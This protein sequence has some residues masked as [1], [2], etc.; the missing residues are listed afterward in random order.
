[1]IARVKY[2]VRIL[3]LVFLGVAIGISYYIAYETYTEMS[4]GGGE[5]GE[6]I[7]LLGEKAP[8]TELHLG[9]V[10]EAKEVSGE[11]SV[12]SSGGS[13]SPSSIEEKIRATF[14]EEPTTAVAVAMC[15]SR[16]D[17]S[18]IGDTHIQEPSYGLFQINRFYNPQYSVD[19]LSTVDGN[20]KAAREI[21]EEGGW[22]RWSCYRFNY[23]QK[24]L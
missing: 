21:Y 18:R 11:D 8:V 4:W 15:E 7:A 16:L 23:Y 3:G 14:P 6:Y 2:N 24:F 5:T 17:N 19:E 9:E 13:P 22:N 12:D 10:A 1:M 20:L